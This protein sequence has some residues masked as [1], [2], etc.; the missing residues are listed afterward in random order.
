M[1]LRLQLPILNLPAKAIVTGLALPWAENRQRI[2]SGDVHLE[3]VRGVFHKP[4][5]D[6]PPLQFLLQVDAGWR[7]HVERSTSGLCEYRRA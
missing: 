3:G 2:P 1:A 6:S 4:H 7:R 5:D